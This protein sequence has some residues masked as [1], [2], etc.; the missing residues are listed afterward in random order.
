MRRIAVDMTDSG[1]V[2][3][4]RALHDDE[5]PGPSEY[6][7]VPASQLRGAVER[8]EKAERLVALYRENGS[9]DLTRMVEYEAKIAERGQ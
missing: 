7:Y 3:G 9:P 5:N 2:L 6:E 8:A 4:A 1:I